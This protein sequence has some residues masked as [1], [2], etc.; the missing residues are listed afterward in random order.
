[1]HEVKQEEEADTRIIVKSSMII[2]IN[3]SSLFHRGRQLQ[4]NV[5]P[6]SHD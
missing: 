2:I 6:L 1:M 4:A 5:D 3:L